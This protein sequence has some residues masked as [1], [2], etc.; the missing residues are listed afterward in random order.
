MMTYGATAMGSGVAG[1]VM[2]HQ[3]LK[4]QPQTPLNVRQVFVLLAG[5]APIWSLGGAANDGCMFPEYIPQ[6]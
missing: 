5:P 1:L 3:P 2:V 4:I 6:N